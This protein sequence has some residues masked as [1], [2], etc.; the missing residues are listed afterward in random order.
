MRDLEGNEPDNEYEVAHANELPRAPLAGLIVELLGMD[1]ARKYV[2][3]PR[4]RENDDPVTG[5]P[6][7]DGECEACRAFSWHLAPRHPFTGA[8]F[9]IWVCPK[10][11][12]EKCSECDLADGHG[13]LHHQQVNA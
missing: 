2:A 4:L 6:M 11:R 10:C 7:R 13:G 3:T 5:D 9:S 8:D 1:A 12:H